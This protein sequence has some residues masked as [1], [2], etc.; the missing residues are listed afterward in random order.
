[1]LYSKEPENLSGA[2]SPPS[3]VVWQCLAEARPVLAPQNG[4]ASSTKSVEHLV[5]SPLI[6]HNRCLGAL[7]IRLPAS[8]A[9]RSSALDFIQAL[10]DQAA[11]SIER[12]LNLKSAQEARRRADAANQAKSTFLANMSH[13]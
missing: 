13:E 8:T 2:S 10:S 3:E 5:A 7:E 9:V 11:Q 6:V 1:L 4:S 12:G